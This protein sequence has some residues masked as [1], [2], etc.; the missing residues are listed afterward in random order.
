MTRL[1]SCL[2]VVLLLGGFGAVAYRALLAQ[3]EAGKG[4][5]R[6]SVYSDEGDG[7]AEAYRLVRKFGWRPVAL[8][9]PIQHT[10][11]RG[12]LVLVDPH[13]GSPVPGLDTEVS[14]ADAR[15][16]RRW[17]EAGNT[18]LLCGRRM[19]AVHDELGLEI[20]STAEGPA[21]PTPAAAGEAGGYTRGIDRLVVEGRDAVRAEDGL[22]LWWVQ[23]EPGAVLLVRGRGRLLVVADPSLL[24]RR[25]LGRADNGLFLYN[26]CG[27]DARDGRVYFDEYHH[28]LGSGGGLWSYLRY[29]GRAWTVLQLVL[30]AAVAVWAVAARLGPALPRG[31]AST[32]D[33]VDYASAV[34][35][36]YQRAGVRDLLARALVRDFMDAVRRPVH[37]RRN[38]LPAEVLA[39]WQRHAGEAGA[40]DRG[41]SSATRR[42]RELLRVVAR[43]RSGHCSPHQLLAWARAFDQF[44][45]E[46]LRVR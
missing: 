16:L 40:G 32:A 28:G 18:L 5:P 20:T 30:V 21:L 41:S 14:E 36:I 6:Y 2:L 10:H 4:M 38:A 27:M 42:L 33:A 37:L 3:A 34:A 29:H 1:H 26:V 22:P 31:R 24:T 13:Q 12:L 15:A 9:R 39:A 19:N 23:D 44:K 11:D 17:V 8:T 46:V 25:G 45:A 43:L 7:L 35:R